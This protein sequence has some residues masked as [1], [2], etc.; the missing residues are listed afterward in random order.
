[1]SQAI[2]QP[3]IVKIRE[4]VLKKNDILARQLRERFQKEQVYVVNVVD[5]KSV[6]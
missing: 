2:E 6:V 1:M 5:R 4:N 3:R